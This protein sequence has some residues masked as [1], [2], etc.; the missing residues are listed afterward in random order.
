MQAL[1]EL[2]ANA[3]SEIDAA[4]DLVSLDKLR[5][6]YLGK[7]GELTDRLKGVSQLP[8]NE[9]PAAGQDINRA[10]QDVQQRLNARRDALESEALEKSWPKMLSTSACRVVVRI[11]AVAI[12]CRG[13]CY[14]SRKSSKTRASEFVPVLKSKMISTISPR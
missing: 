7:K 4:G 5:V 1:N 11:L 8:K 14:G 3:A 13:R 10:K 12:R 6:R 9:R 2:I